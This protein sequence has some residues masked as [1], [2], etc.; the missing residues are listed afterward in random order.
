MTVVL[1]PVA[2][3]LACFVTLQWELVMGH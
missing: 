2:I 1:S 3:D